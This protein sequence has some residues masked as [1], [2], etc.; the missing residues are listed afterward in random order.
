MR[1][2]AYHDPR[3]QVVI[4]LVCAREGQREQKLWEARSDARKH[5]VVRISARPNDRME[6][7]IEMVSFK[8]VVLSRNAK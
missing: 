5:W 6:R 7:F 1:C 2:T 3:S 8:G 4:P